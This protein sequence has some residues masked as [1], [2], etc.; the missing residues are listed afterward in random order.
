MFLVSVA[1]RRSPRKLD[2]RDVHTFFPC[3]VFMR[4]PERIT[5]VHG[6]LKTLL[7][8]GAINNWMFWNAFEGL[9]LTC[10]IRS[11]TRDRK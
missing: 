2:P 5:K 7:L 10:K 8:Y 3:S 6:G 11:R 4:V 1:P 9:Y